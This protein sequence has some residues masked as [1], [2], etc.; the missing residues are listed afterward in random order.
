MP[1]TALARDVERSRLFRVS[2]A[3][4]QDE[5]GA[6]KVAAVLPA[7]A[8]C[9]VNLSE[10]AGKLCDH[11]VPPSAVREMLDSLNLDVRVFD[12]TLAYATGA[13]RSS[14]AKLGFSLGD[15]ACLALARQLGV[16]TLTADHAWKR[17]QVPGIRVELIR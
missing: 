4:L 1:S 6:D 3:L 15:R 2:L 11:G 13:L 10:V 17:I 16:P 7:A 12:A 8:L 5:A 9:S 14:T